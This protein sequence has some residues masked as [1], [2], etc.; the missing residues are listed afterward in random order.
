MHEYIA[1]S[2]APFQ[3]TLNLGIPRKGKHDFIQNFFKDEKFRIVRSFLYVESGQ[4]ENKT[5]DRESHEILTQNL[6]H[7]V[8]CYQIP[9]VYFLHKF[10]EIS[11]LLPLSV[12]LVGF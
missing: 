12:E 7:E 5:V 1:D 11:L 10:V 9:I 3:R 8:I 6:P 2:F 4:H